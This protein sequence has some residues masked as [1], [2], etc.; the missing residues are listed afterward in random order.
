MAW[1][2]WRVEESEAWFRRHLPETDQCPECVT[3]EHKR[4][5]WFAGRYL[6]QYLFNLEGVH[7]QGLQK[8]RFGKPFPVGSSAQ[9]SLTNSFPHVAVQVDSSRPVGI[10]LETVRP[11]MLKVV[12]RILT[13]REAADAGSDLVKNGVYWCAK[14][15]AFKC[16][17]TRPVSL[18][19]DIAIQPFP[20]NQHGQ[21][22]ATVSLAG[23]R[24]DVELEYFIEADHIL[25]VT[26]FSN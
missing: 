7:Y 13:E 6:I 1:A 9:I 8:D 5:E 25:V 4:L 12:P 22:F 3:H 23:L 11:Q 10:D 16:M 15:A 17:G 26:H 20:L 21:V 24:H 2:V 19:H 18:R 14:E